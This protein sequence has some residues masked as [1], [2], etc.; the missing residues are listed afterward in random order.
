MNENQKSTSDCL[1]ESICEHCENT[2]SQYNTTHKLCD[3]CLMILLDQ[4]R[5]KN[6]EIEELKNTIQLLEM[7]LDNANRN[8]K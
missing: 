7:E 5:N 2:I 8:T 3:G 4:I 1:D 6:Q